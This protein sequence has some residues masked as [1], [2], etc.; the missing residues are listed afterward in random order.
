MHPRKNLTSEM[1]FYDLDF[2]NDSVDIISTIGKISAVRM[3]IL[4]LLSAFDDTNPTRLGPALHPRSPPSASSAN[5][6]VEPFGSFAEDS[7]NVPGH[8]MPTL[9]PLNAQPIIDSAGRGDSEMRRYD[10]MHRTLH[11][12]MAFC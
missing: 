4:R 6:A 5:I 9:N 3:P 10:I 8:I 11:I 1:R 12:G 7:E 2:F